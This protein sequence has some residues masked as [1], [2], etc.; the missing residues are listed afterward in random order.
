MLLILQLGL[1]LLFKSMGIWMS[2]EKII[3]N[4]FLNLI[5]VITKFGYL[6]T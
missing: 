2:I 4:I 6:L 3:K 1:L 5:R